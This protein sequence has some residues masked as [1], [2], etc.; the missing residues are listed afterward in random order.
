VRGEYDRFT[1]L[2][3][4][5]VEAVARRV[6]ELLQ[7]SLTALETSAFVEPKQ[8][9]PGLVD[10]P[11]VARELGVSVDYV[12][13]HQNELGVRRLGSGKKPRLRFDLAESR[14]AFDGHPGDQKRTSDSQ[15]SRKGRKRR[16]TTSVP[17]LPFRGEGR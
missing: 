12:Y 2:S 14:A 17:L 11:T 9:E 4:E 10:A 7:K 3:P 13:A 8:A 15:P 6:A 1:H 5:S 16:H